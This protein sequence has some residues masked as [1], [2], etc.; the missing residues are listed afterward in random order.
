[1]SFGW[2]RITSN[3]WSLDDVWQ[4]VEE[5]SGIWRSYRGNDPMLC[6]FPTVE[7]AMHEAERLREA[8]KLYKKQD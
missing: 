5:R 1:M 6:D 4:V 3:V 2:K 7:G 8:D